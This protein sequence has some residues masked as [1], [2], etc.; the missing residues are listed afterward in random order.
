MLTG[1]KLYALIHFDTKKNSEKRN[2][3]AVLP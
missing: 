2:D 1:M 3:L